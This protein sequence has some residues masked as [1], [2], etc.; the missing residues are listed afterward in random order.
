[1]KSIY[2]YDISEA[3]ICRITGPITNIL[4]A[5]EQYGDIKIWAEV[6][7][8]IPD[9]EYEISVVGM[10]FIRILPGDKVTIALSS[11]DLTRGRITFRHK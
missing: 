10:N 11:Y 6:D 5:G 9:R 4:C 1:M 8:M 2:K 3:P 7:T